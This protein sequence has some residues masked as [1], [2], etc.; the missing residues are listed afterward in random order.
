MTTEVS[1]EQ[2]PTYLMGRSEAETRR[3][4]AQH[5]LYGPFT[6]RL[7]EDA[8]IREGMKVLDAGSGA[9]DV[10]LLTAELVGPTGS[11]V[12]VDQ[13]PEVLKIASARAEATGLTNI[14]FHVGE[15]REGVPG[16]DFDAVV[17][18]LVLLYVPDPA[19]TLRG[20]VERL[21]PGGI[22]AFGEFNFLPASVVAH[23]PTPTS[24]RLWAWMQAVVRG[25]GLDPATG[26][27]LRNT[28][29]D[30][31]LP[32]PE[33]NVCAPVG[34]GPD[35][36][37]Y[38]YSAESLR[39][40]LPLILKLGIA[41]ADEVDIDTL[42]QRLRAEIVGSGGVLKTPDLVGAWTRKEGDDPR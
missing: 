31:G 27:H 33:M 29:I 5:R 12:G 7:L 35:F 42:A 40:M 20:L 14:S 18:R 6:R 37:G 21:K 19:G 13:D 11:V 3:L 32:E 36:P 8:G 4:M 28:F 2:S 23:P 41:T 38:D 39:S 30:A 10:A 9:G 16:H 22:V 25:I 17:G 24:E 34:G 26:Y 15:L 1:R